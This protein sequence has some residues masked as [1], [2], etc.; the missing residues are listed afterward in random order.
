VPNKSD[1]EAAGTAPDAA[2]SMTNHSDMRGLP[3]R[4]EPPDLVPSGA[5]SVERRESPAPQ[6][7]CRIVQARALQSCL[8]RVRTTSGLRMASAHGS[9]SPALRGVSRGGGLRQVG[10]HEPDQLPSER[11]DRH[12]R[13]LAVSDE[14]PIPPAEGFAVCA[15]RSRPFQGNLPEYSSLDSHASRLAWFMSF[16]GPE[17]RASGH[18]ISDCA[19][20]MPRMGPQ[21]CGTLLPETF[22]RSYGDGH[23]DGIEFFL[24]RWPRADWESRRNQPDGPQHWFP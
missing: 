5:A 14:M 2:A 15:G 13:A 10:P 23:D 3:C 4:A 17:R 11:H 18:C 8:H 1:P 9:T 21:H 7:G 24:T 16:C 6:P 20:A 12:R 22:R 19:T